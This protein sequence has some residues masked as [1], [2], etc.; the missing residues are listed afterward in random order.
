MRRGTEGSDT[1]APPPPR[2]GSERRTGCRRLVV[3]SERRTAAGSRWNGR[4]EQSRGP[5]GDDGQTGMG[6]K[7]QQDCERRRRIWKREG[8][9]GGCGCGRAHRP[10]AG[11]ATRGGKK[12]TGGVRRG[13][14]GACGQDT[15][16]PRRAARYAV[17]C[18]GG[19]WGG[20]A[21][22]GDGRSRC[23]TTDRWGRSRRGP[24]NG[25]WLSA[26]GSARRPADGDVDRP[27]GPWPGGAQTAIIAAAQTLRF[28]LKMGAND[29]E[30]KRTSTSP[31]C[32]LPSDLNFLIELLL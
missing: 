32:Q 31:L 13:R 28:P 3:V 11:A 15:D 16:G 18:G 6:G 1:R 26:A 22:G 17:T 10:R 12:I 9:G 23:G 29:T 2:D 25:Q 21:P 7:W 5:R 20:R 8:G 30:K 4:R 19:G 14:A 27:G 24:R